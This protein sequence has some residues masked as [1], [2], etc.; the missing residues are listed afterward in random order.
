MY[1]KTNK[2]DEARFRDMPVNSVR[3]TTHQ[4][5]TKTM[6][7]PERPRNLT[8]Y[9]PQP[10]DT[11]GI[12]LSQGIEEL[13]EQLA[14]HAHEV[15]ARQRIS[16]GWTWGPARDDDSKQ[17]PCLVPYHE[18]DDSEQ[19]YY[20]NASLETLKVILAKGYHINPPT[21][22]RH[23][24]PG[25]EVRAMSDAKKLLDLSWFS[26]NWNFG[27]FE[28]VRVGRHPVEGIAASCRE[29]LSL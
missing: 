1:A 27:W 19:Q 4:P 20:R 13:T 5:I 12:K 2:P 22:G 9:E 11:S 8:T 29:G 26:V 3:C 17:H 25:N 14:K 7:N 15:W 24:E 18:L 21:D 28:L 6:S 10:V 16:D 23:A